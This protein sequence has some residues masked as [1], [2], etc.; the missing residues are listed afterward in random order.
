MIV[1]IMEKFDQK[2]YIREYKKKKYRQFTAKLPIEEK[3]EIDSFL[4]Q[5]NMNNT[6]FI[7]EAYKLLKEKYKR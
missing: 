4:D 6:Q 7:R 3:E 5:I 1:K 2:K